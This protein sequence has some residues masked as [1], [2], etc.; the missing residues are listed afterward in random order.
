MRK[1]QRKGSCLLLALTMAVAACGLKTYAAANNNCSVPQFNISFAPIP[2]A[3]RELVNPMRGLYTTFDGDLAPEPHTPYLNYYRF[4]WSDIETSP[5]QFDFSKVET[6][7]AKAQA[8]NAK[9]A[10][11]VMPVAYSAGSTAGAPTV[12]VPSDFPARLQKGYFISYPPGT[13][14]AGKKLY[15]PDY[16]DPIYIQRAQALIKALAVKY[17]GDPRI[18]YVEVSL[19]GTWGEGNYSQMPKTTPTGAL[20]PQFPMARAMADAYAANFSCTR[21]VSPTDIFQIKPQPGDTADSS[22][23]NALEYVLRSYPQAGMFRNSLGDPN[24]VTWFGAPFQDPYVQAAG[25]TTRWQTAPCTGE[26]F[27]AGSN[28]SPISPQ[29]VYA[30]TEVPQYHVSAVANGALGPAKNL[31][32]T[33]LQNLQLVGK[34]AGYRFQLDQATGDQLIYTDAPFTLTSTW[35]NTGVT[36]AYEPWVVVYQLRRT[37]G[38]SQSVSWQGAS[39][40]DLRRLLPTNGQTQTVTDTFKLKR[41]LPPGDYQLTIV[42][43]DPKMFYHT[44]LTLASSGQQSDGS[45]AVATVKVLPCKQNHR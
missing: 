45:Y 44:P 16:N 36:P 41:P 20:P 30:E 1:S 7:I 12:E 6:E 28:N 26:F 40:L 31:T 37:C 27:G 8:V 5:G 38:Q 35:E 17:D 15:I 34:L 29:I 11:R 18:A 9:F 39:A 4:F 33:D 23:H 13:V 22:Y 19:I 32:A 3:N 25:G 43:E 10:F 21:I 24:T 42:I 2:I 14:N